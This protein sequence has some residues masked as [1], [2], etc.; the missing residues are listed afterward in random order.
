MNM[1]GNFQN[2]IDFH[3]NRTQFN[4]DILIA[5]VPVN[6]QI[7]TCSIIYTAI[8]VVNLIYKSH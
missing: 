5:V 6:E 2:S 3:V 1:N 7:Y 8:V 4:I